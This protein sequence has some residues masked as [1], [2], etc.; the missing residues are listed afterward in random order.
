MAEVA[1]DE[2]AVWLDGRR[3]Q[4]DFKRYAGL[5][6]NTY[7]AELAPALDAEALPGAL[8]ILVERG[9]ELV[10]RAPPSRFVE[11]PGAPG[12]GPWP[13]HLRQH[14]LLAAW[15]ERRS[16]RAVHFVSQTDAPALIR[17]PTILTVHDVVQHRQGE[18]YRPPP[19]VAADR[20]IR[21][22]MALVRAL[23]RRAI[24]QAR[25]I[26][27]PSRV[28]AE[29]LISTL[30]VP[31]ARIAV[32]PEAASPR[33]RPEASERDVAVRR[34]LALPD[35]YLL[36]PGGAD[37][38]KRLPELVRVFD[39]IA[40]TDATLG[41]VLVGPVRSGDGAAELERA[42]AMAAA[43][44]RIRV[45]GVLD[46]ADLAAVYRGARAVVLAS[47]YEGFGLPVV[48]GFACGVPVVATAAPAIAE[49][50]GDAALL[51]PVDDVHTL[52]A[53]VK[54]VL[55]GPARAAELRARGLARA[56][57]FRWGVA[58]VETLSVYEDVL[59]EPLG[60]RSSR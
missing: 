25:R 21:L 39:E 55:E 7:V 37:P 47:R 23:E 31:R 20:A 1:G 14:L 13:T 44:A 53:A 12:R 2:G 59:G 58:A 29:E 36:H 38:R 17:V 5:G 33:L 18:W 4:T 52:V 60:I 3:L 54:S 51:V 32:I 49:V 57:Q 45:C 30:G 26:I 43:S 28:T 35:R 24:A 16:P 46:D 27:V 8:R 10:T 40:R 15:L 19:G 50:A 6:P 42:V 48:E 56:A 22:R 34:R 11:V 9:A 41:L